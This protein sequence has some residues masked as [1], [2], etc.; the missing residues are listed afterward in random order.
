MDFPIALTDETVGSSCYKRESPLLGADYLSVISERIPE[1]I[2][3]VDSVGIWA[4]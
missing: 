2:H 4:R 1:I 3:S